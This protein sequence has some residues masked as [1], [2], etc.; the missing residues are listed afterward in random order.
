M[1]PVLAAGLIAYL[2]FLAFYAIFGFFLIYHVQRFS[3]SQ[4]VATTMTAFFIT[5]SIIVIIVTVP[6]FYGID[7]NAPLTNQPAPFGGLGL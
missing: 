1:S 3:I 6:V 4:R 5:V 2:A 7:W